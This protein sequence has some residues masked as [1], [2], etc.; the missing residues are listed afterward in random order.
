MKDSVP[1]LKDFLSFEFIYLLF[2][3]A[4]TFKGSIYLKEIN[5]FADLTLVLLIVNVIFGMFIYLRAGKPSQGAISL[6]YCICFLLFGLYGLINYLFSGGGPFADT[7]I[8]HFL[9]L[10]S[11]AVLA[12]VLI[13]RADQE[14]INRFIRLLW[15]YFIIFALSFLLTGVTGVEQVGGL[16]SSNY[17]T[18]GNLAAMAIVICVSLFNFQKSKKGKFLLLLLSS[19]LFIP[20]IYSGSRQS[21]LG[22]VLCLAI[23]FFM[24]KLERKIIYISLLLIFILLGVGLIN[25]T[26]S[27]L[28]D[29]NALE[30]RM[31]RFMW[32]LSNS[33]QGASIN[34]RYVFWS[35][36]LNMWQEHPIWGYGIGKY[37]ETNEVNAYPHNQFLEVLAELGIVGLI[38]LLSLHFIAFTAVIKSGMFSTWQGK[39]LVLITFFYF[40]STMVSGDLVSQRNLF[41]FSAMICV[42][43]DYQI[44]SKKEGSKP[45]SSMDLS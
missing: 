36:A 21:I 20:L 17:Q 45:E 13:I 34:L 9:V 5:A 35:D 4:G 1:R 10:G 26:S 42:F 2:I 40:V 31:Q 22:L 32:A 14:R 11:W 16:G 6:S 28:S 7:K 41:A 38:F 27:S 30:L 39:I 18:L 19:F 43:A 12:P 44:I 29:N 23:I 8:L 37:P 33:N 3:F 25:I 15:V 24:E